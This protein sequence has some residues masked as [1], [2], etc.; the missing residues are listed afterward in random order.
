MVDDVVEVVLPDF[1]GKEAVNHSLKSQISGPVGIEI[2]RG[3]S[4]G[5]RE[6]L[7]VVSSYQGCSAVLDSLETEV[8]GVVD[9]LGGVVDVSANV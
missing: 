1:G 4:L 5:K 7:V 3:D 6:R 8:T 2:D 9:D